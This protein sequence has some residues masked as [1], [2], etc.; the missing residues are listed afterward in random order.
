V[1]VGAIIVVNRPRNVIGWILCAAGLAFALAS[2]ADDFG[3]YVPLRR[4]QWLPGTLVMSWF[5]P[6]LWSLGFGLV[7]TFLVLL[8]PDGR[9]PSRRWRPV[10]WA[11]A[12]DLAVLLVLA[13]FTPKPAAGPVGMS[14]PL[15]I[16]RAAGLFQMVQPI[17]DTALY[18]LEFLCLVSLVLR[19]RRSRGVQR[20]QLKWFTFA[21]LVAAGSLVFF[22]PTGLDEQLSGPLLL[23]CIL[24]S[25]WTLPAAI[26][27][28]ILRYRLYDIDR[29]INRTLVFGLLTVLL[30]SI[31]AGAVLI[32]GQA[33]NPSGGDS[34]LAVAASTL[35]VA[36]LFQPLRR[37]IQ[38]TVNR[39]FNRRRYDAAKSIEAFNTRLRDQVDLDTLSADMLSVVAHTMQPTKA[40][41]WLRP[42]PSGSSDTA[43]SE[44]G[45]TTWAY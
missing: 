13:A 16:E 43:A 28:A 25:L 11:A 5:G 41:L 7:G 21:V 31:Y 18:A 10:A 4:P 32:F 44:R 26:G 1:T 36:A 20:Q 30:G 19:F 17:A 3:V 8:F 33:L 37:R 2:F 23:I 34:P 12:V 39:R 24:V 22:G 35:L 9:L 38:G 14:I 40:S 29:L 15:G 6:W 45:P 27:I 42:P